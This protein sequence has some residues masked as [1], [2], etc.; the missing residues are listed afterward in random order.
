VVAANRAATREA[1]EH[2]IAHG[3]QR[4]AFLSDW[5]SLYTTA[6]RCRGYLDAHRAQRLPVRD[7]LQ[8]SGLT[9]V[10]NA[11]HALLTLVN[12][13]APPTAVFAANN[14]TCLRVLHALHRTGLMGT[15]ALIGFDDIECAQLLNP[16][17]SVLRQDPAAMGRLAAQAVFA[18]L[19]GQQPTGQ[20]LQVPVTLVPR[21][22]G[23]LTGHRTPTHR[24]TPAR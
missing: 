20:Q 4:I 16:P 17:L 24:V 10:T 19:A 18:Q 12:D 2:L 1:V 7:D 11:Q 6:Q 9:D 15:I 14:R 8:R 22:S 21:G 13:K 5:P 3:H 23:E